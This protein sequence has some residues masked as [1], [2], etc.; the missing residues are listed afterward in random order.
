MYCRAM[1]VFM[2]SCGCELKSGD[3]CATRHISFLR[4][5]LSTQ[6]FYWLTD[7]C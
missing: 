1:T 6:N 4:N 5:E 3:I 7:S 2:L